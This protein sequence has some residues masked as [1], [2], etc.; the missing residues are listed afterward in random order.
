ANVGIINQIDMWFNLYFGK[1]ETES[2]IDKMRFHFCPRVG[3]HIKCFNDE[4]VV[5]KVIHT[6]DIV[7]LTVGMA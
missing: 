2:F 3:E 5:E 6:E 7:I 4:Y 1:I